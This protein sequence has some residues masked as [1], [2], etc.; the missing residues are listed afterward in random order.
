MTQAP[1]NVTI[2][3][4]DSVLACKVGLASAEIEGETVLYDEDAQVLH[5]LDPIGTVV[6]TLLDGTVTLGELCVDLAD[7][8]AA[9]LSQVQNDVLRLAGD[10]SEKGLLV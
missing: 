5:L 4:L 6:W 9:D 7:V 10:L 3:S 1:D 8:F 2:P